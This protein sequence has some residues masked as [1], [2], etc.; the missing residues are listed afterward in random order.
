MKPTSRSALGFAVARIHR[1][2]TTV[3]HALRRSARPFAALAVLCAVAPL[4]AKPVYQNGSAA[5]NV[6]FA[7]PS[8]IGNDS[9]LD[10]NTNYGLVPFP[11]SKWHEM[12]GTQSQ[13]NNRVSVT[14]SSL[15]DSAENGRATVTI[16]ARV[17]EEQNANAGAIL[18]RDAAIDDYNTGKPESTLTIADI[19]YNCYDVYLYMAGEVYDYNSPVRIKTGNEYSDYYYMP[20]NKEAALTSPTAQPWG[21]AGSWSATTLG[22][23]VMRI[24]DRTSSSITFA[25]QQLS[26]ARANF[27]AIQIVERVALPTYEATLAEN[28]SVAATEL[29]VTL[30]SGGTTKKLSEVTDAESVSIALAGN[31][32]ISGTVTAKHLQVTGTGT[33]IF[34]DA[35]TV[36]GN[37]YAE[38]G[39]NLVLKNAT[40]SGATA[41]SGGG[42]VNLT[43]TSLGGPVTATTDL[44]LTAPTNATETSPCTITRILTIGASGKTL[45]SL[46]TRG[47][48]KFINTGN[49]FY[50]PLIVENGTLEATCDGQGIK[51]GL[52]IKKKGT[53]KGKSEDSDK[54]N[55]SAAVT[56][57]V[58]G[59][60]DMNGTR[61][62]LGSGNVIN[63]YP[64]A[65]VKGDGQAFTATGKSGMYGAFDANADRLSMNFKRAANAEDEQGGDITFS[66]SLRVRGA[67]RVYT[68]DVAE[69][70]T[71]NFSGTRSTGQ[72]TDN[73]DVG[74]VAKT[75]QGK[76]VLQGDF[77]LAGASSGPIEVQNTKTLTFS[78]GSSAVAHTASITGAGSVVLTGENTTLTLP[79]KTETAID[80][81]NSATLKIPVTEEE[82][83]NGYKALKVTVT[84]GTVKFVALDGQEIAATGTGNNELASEIVWTGSG[85]GFSWSDK[86]NWQGNAV[87]SA[88]SYVAIPLTGNLS[89]TLPDGGAPVARLRVSGTEAAHTLTLLG[90]ALTVS[91]RILLAGAN[92][93]ATTV[94]LPLTNVTAIDLGERTTLDYTVTSDMSLPALT[95]TGTL[96]LGENVTATVTGLL[97]DATQPDSG[98]G[99]A[100]SSHTFTLGNGSTL[101]LQPSV[102]TQ[103][104]GVISGAGSLVVGNGKAASTVKLTGANTYTGTTTVAVGAKL[105]LAG[106]G[107][108]SDAFGEDSRVIVDGTLE[109]AAGSYCRRTTGAGTICVLN[110]LTFA[111]GQAALPAGEQWSDEKTTGLTG[112]TGTLALVGNLKLT[113]AASAF[114]TYA[115]TGFSVRFEADDQGSSDGQLLC[116]ETGKTSFTL[117][118]GRTLSGKGF[119]KCPIAFEANSVIEVKMATNLDL[120]KATI[121][122][123]SG[124]GEHILLKA[125]VASNGFL[126]VAL[127]ANVPASVFAFADTSTVKSEDA[128]VKVYRYQEDYDVV[129]VIA[130]PR[131]PEGTAAGV[132]EAIRDQANIEGMP[133][134]VQAVKKD[135]KKPKVVLEGTLFFENVVKTEFSYE[136]YLVTATV[137]YDFGVSAITVK[138]LTLEGTEQLCVV[139]C[140]KVES[141][142][143]EGKKATF[144][145]S[146]Q[147]QLYLNGAL[148][149]AATALT[150][151][152]DNSVD[153]SDKS[154]RWFAVPLSS[155]PDTVTSNFTVKVTEAVTP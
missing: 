70:V 137:T 91:G 93:T 130:N 77:T 6:N 90:G 100:N 147:V 117:A 105:S 136:T 71:V 53:F 8:K 49:T 125:A 37:I 46:V 44:I 28:T 31:A 66:S 41:I 76:L 106:N 23:N 133:V 112:F 59:T 2:A 32:T 58:Y 114:C 48:L 141:S 107:V 14:A 1:V 120:S 151:T 3:C 33:L 86:T 79:E 119:V 10:A 145:E 40:T 144:K 92:L 121:T 75:G 11:G 129:Q 82:R 123:P 134:T 4:W 135:E 127:S 13:S 149:N 35:V 78:S 128:G 38:T 111:I 116:D 25:T 81:R 104:A 83:Q 12:S 124:E 22:V 154:V 152:I 146:A 60:L 47:F 126:Y 131:V 30:N 57:D 139:V 109:L 89:L 96:A 17:F 64:G 27:A 132:A 61:W 68:L 62:T 5:L 85:D 155:L 142:A 55:Y 20:T 113:N 18:L 50:S 140:A 98:V 65:T 74:L 24:A 19:P 16:N 95:G 67:T 15:T 103:L 118:V 108:L 9:R 63:V 153:D 39:A 36:A 73:A 143:I 56:V 52:V 101:K 43:P 80:V 42:T 122:L 150:S 34:S 110:N 99:S 54:L 29:N 21:S 102:S 84:A 72:A 88:T 148:C 97:G 94:T 51:G 7:I 87:P 138:R 115:P 45:G 26:N 69:G